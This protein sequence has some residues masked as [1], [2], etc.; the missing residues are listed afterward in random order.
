MVKKQNIFDAV[1]GSHA[2]VIHKTLL[3][4]FWRNF[5][6]DGSQMGG[7]KLKREVLKSNFNDGV[8]TQDQRLR[9]LVNYSQIIIGN[10]KNI[11]KK[12]IDFNDA[13]A[14]LHRSNRMIN[15]KCFVCLGK[16]NCRHHIIQL[17]N[18]G[19]NQKKNL[20]SLCNKCHSDIHP[21][22]K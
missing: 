16:A 14:K 10:P 8:K 9:L 20:V 4:S 21:W 17:Q 7:N 15:T 18:G 13:K 1:N 19:L 6:N 2:Q 11:F 3:L 12:R 5:I 22:L